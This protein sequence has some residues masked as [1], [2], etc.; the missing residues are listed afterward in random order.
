MREFDTPDAIFTV[1]DVRGHAWVRILAAAL[2]R[3]WRTGPATVGWVRP[4]AEEA[5]EAAHLL[6]QR[7]RLLQ[8][9]E[10]AT[11]RQF[12]EPAQVGE[13]Q[14]GLPPRRAGYVARVDR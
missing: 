2:L 14:L 13:P 8:R 11:S 7:L 5:E 4:S 3:C 1:I 12:L 6:D 10:V 9:G